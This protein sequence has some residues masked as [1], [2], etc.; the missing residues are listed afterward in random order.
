MECYYVCLNDCILFWKIDC[1]DY[2]VLKNCLK[3][4]GDCYIS[5]G[6][7]VRCFYYYFFGLCFKR[8]YDCREILSLL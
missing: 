8:L 3:C 5:N 1:Y 7:L 2:F 4:N 6:K